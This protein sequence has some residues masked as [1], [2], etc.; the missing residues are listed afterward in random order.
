MPFDSG[1]RNQTG[2]YSSETTKF[3]FGITAHNATTSAA[4]YYSYVRTNY[5]NYSENFA[6][7]YWVKVQTTV[8]TGVSVM[9]AAFPYRN[10]IM[11]A[12]QIFETYHTATGGTSS[13]T[14]LNN[15]YK[16]N[17]YS[18]TAPRRTAAI[19]S[20]VLQVLRDSATPGV[21][22]MQATAFTPSNTNNYFSYSLYVQN[23]NSVRYFR[24]GV[25]RSFVD[26]DLSSVSVI[27]SSGVQYAS[28]KTV[29]TSAGVFL[30]QYIDITN[31]IRN[32][33]LAT[34]G[35][36]AIVT[37]GDIGFQRAHTGLR[38]LTDLLTQPDIFDQIKITDYQL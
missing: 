34:T 5:L 26:F 18:L 25:D 31:P 32:V 33:L 10:T 23:V 13:Y 16:N 22:Y 1:F 11:D 8:S 27:T 28:I 21:H 3:T 7:D 6:Q 37:T 38:T 20:N 9:A 2:Q 15:Y 30:C 29:D 4:T 36:A 17:W 24:M 19:T 14:Y 12:N 35:D